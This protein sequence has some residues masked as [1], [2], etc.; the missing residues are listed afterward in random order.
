MEHQSRLL[1]TIGQIA[2]AMTSRGHGADYDPE[3]EGEAAAVDLAG[4]EVRM[5]TPVG[6]GVE[7]EGVGGEGVEGEV[8][9]L[10]LTLL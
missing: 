6:G 1:D 4:G 8:I 2:Q 9:K 3:V 10:Q 5:R 7:E